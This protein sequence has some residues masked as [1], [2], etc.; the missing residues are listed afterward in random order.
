MTPGAIAETPLLDSI[1]SMDDLRSMSEQDLIALCEELRF[2]LMHRVNQS[3]GHF[4]SSLG[5]TELTVALH[6]TFNTPN[7]RLVWDVGHQAYV[8]KILTGRREQMLKV[9]TLG[10]IS[11]FP[12]RSESEFDTFGV[13]HAGTS[14]S[15]ALGMLEAG[16]HSSLGDKDSIENEKKVIAV[17]GDGAMTAGMAFEALN[18]AG[19]LHKNLIVVLN[20]NEMSI[21]PNVGALSWAFSRAVTT[22]LSTV[23]RKHFKSLTERGLIPKAF[24]RALDRAEE[25]TQGFLSTPAMLFSAFGF[26]YIGPVD[27]HNMSQLISSLNRAKD[28]D[29]PVLIHVLTTKGKGYEPAEQDPVG[30]HAITPHQLL[31]NPSP[32][33]NEAQTA[34]NIEISERKK[35]AQLPVRQSY[36]KVFGEALVEICQTDSRVI[37]ITAAMPD[38]TGLNILCETMPERYYDVGIAEQ[39]AVTFAAG[40]ACEGMRPVCAIYSTFLQR[41]YDQVVHD[42]CIQNLPVVFVMDRAGLVG[43][44]GPTHHGVFDI[45][46]LRSLPN[47]TIMS[48]KDEAELRDML[49]TAIQYTSGPTAIRYP[50]GNGVGVPVNKTMKSLEIGKGEIISHTDGAEVAIIGYGQMVQT[51]IE[52]AAILETN[53]IPSTVINARFVKPLDKSLLHEL[54]LTHELL[55]TVED[56]ALQGGFGSA[57]LEFLS[58][59]NLHC[60]L[61]RLGIPDQFIEHGTQSELYESLGLNSKRLSEKVIEH[62]QSIN[63]RKVSV[64]A[65]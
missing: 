55:V 15:A 3:G 34:K 11:G 51:A 41:A 47:M 33:P 8:H 13:A 58:D 30:Y 49:Y 27:G 44:D 39:H 10:G 53:G 2:D 46:Y 36:T 59:S 23:A 22:P 26:R 57:V 7:D 5:V 12:K 64:Q 18:H 6:Y 20:D 42:V 32:E 54:S 62:L 1:N 31:K 37:G 38:G 43:S 60:H 17:I 25:A 50:R 24:Y 65:K 52:S 40:L 28:Q 16:H 56:G 63:V 61:L 21:A 45:S 35:I 48:P 19:H 4:A 29:G 14:I 9:R